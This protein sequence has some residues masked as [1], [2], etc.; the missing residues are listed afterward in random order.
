MFQ[1]FTFHFV[2][3]VTPKAKRQDDID[4]AKSQAYKAW[5]PGGYSAGR[6]FK[7]LDGRIGKGSHA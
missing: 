5:G 7:S 4:T 3:S 2:I 6:K 1:E